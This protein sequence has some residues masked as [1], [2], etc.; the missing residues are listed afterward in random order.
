MRTFDAELR[1]HAMGWCR[2]TA[3][4]LPVPAGRSR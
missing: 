1:Q 2:G 3:S 4:V